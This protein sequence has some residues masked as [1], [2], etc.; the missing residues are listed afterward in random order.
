MAI[1]SSEASIRMTSPDCISISYWPGL[2]IE[3]EWMDTERPHLSCRGS[4]KCDIGE[5]VRTQFPNVPC[6]IST[7]LVPSIRLTCTA[8]SVASFILSI[9]VM[10]CNLG[11][12][13]GNRIHILATP[14][15]LVQLKTELEFCCTT[16][17]SAVHLLHH[18]DDVMRREHLQ[19]LRA[20][21]PSWSA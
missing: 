7:M 3:N 6:S 18:P 9:D 8:M 4:V 1:V 20:D 19:P 2:G 15:N 13:S 17:F 12:S 14:W 11:L 5:N 10:A 16:V 21:S